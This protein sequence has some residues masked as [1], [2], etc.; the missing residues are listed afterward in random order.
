MVHLEVRLVLLVH[1]GLQL[2]A[3][4]RLLSRL[5]LSMIQWRALEARDLLEDHP[6][7]LHSL[8]ALADLQD[9]GVLGE[10]LVDRREVL[11]VGEDLLDLGDLDLRVHL[12]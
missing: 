3:K 4:K 11:A 6:D 8:V 7:N 9:S 12:G 5:V 1:L 10:A 2:L